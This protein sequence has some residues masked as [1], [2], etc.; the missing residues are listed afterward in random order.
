MFVSISSDINAM[1]K[2]KTN[3]R[4]EDD[5]NA[6]KLKCSLVINLQANRK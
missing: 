1:L 5:E 3:V 6:G 4:E 2:W